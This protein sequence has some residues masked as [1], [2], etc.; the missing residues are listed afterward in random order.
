MGAQG[1]VPEARDVE[2]T[3]EED[4]EEPEILCVEEIEAT[5]GAVGAAD[6]S[7]QLLQSLDT[8]G[9]IVEGVRCE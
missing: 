6:G 2:L 8:R 4:L 9:R 1:A 7:R 5:V 3:A